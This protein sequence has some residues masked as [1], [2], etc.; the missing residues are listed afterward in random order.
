MKKLIIFLPILFIVTLVFPNNLSL[1]S[2]TQKVNKEINLSIFSSSNYSA[3]AYDDARATIEITISK[4][5]GDKK[6]VLSKQSYQSMQLKQFPLVAKAISKKLN[7]D[8]VV[9]SNEILMVTYTI[10]YDS[11]GSV[12][13]FENNEVINKK[14]ASDH[15]DISI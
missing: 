5:N 2:H 4:I 7:I 12:I 15:I 10:S 14:T 6:V 13:T 11:N 9:G 1:F 3:A 8:N